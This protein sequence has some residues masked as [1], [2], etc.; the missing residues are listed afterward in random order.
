MIPISKLYGKI[1]DKLQLHPKLRYG[2]ALMNV[3]FESYREAYD[4]VV[5]TQHDCFYVD[6]KVEGTIKYLIDTNHFTSEV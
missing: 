5:A 6:Y 2:Q 4:A 1:Q 3:L